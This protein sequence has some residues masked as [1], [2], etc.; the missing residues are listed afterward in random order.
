M[1]SLSVLMTAYNAADFLDESIS[2][3]LNQTFSD[4]EFFIL[5]NGSTDIS[6]EIIRSYAKQDKRIKVLVNK[7]NKG[8]A[9]AR[10][11]LL[12]NCKTE[13]AAIMDADDISLKNRFKIQLHYMKKYPEVDILGAQMQLFGSGITTQ[14]ITTNTPKTDLAIKSMLLF[15]NGLCHPSVI[16][17]MSKIQQAKI[18]Y[19]ETLPTASDY[20]YL[21]DCCPFVHFDNLSQVLVKYRRHPLQASQKHLPI[22]IRTHIK[23]IKK[24]LIK[25]GIKLPTNLENKITFSNYKIKNLSN[26]DLIDLKK[27]FENILEIAPFYQYPKLDLAAALAALQSII[28]NFWFGRK[29]YKFCQETFDNEKKIIKMI[30]SSKLFQSESN[31]KDTNDFFSF[32]FEDFWNDLNKLKSINQLIKQELLFIKELC[33]INKFL[34]SRK[35]KD[36]FCDAFC[37]QILK[38]ERKKELAVIL[39]YLLLNKDNLTISILKIILLKL[40]IKIFKKFF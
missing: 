29:N 35:I 18:F 5:D 1:P 31:K 12:K 36:V 38:F 33:E 25:L 11:I 22:A 34:N 6:L 7:E 32:I 27:F 39:K 10:N 16:F 8:E 4:F 2:S 30:A 21:V 28:F 9:K 37:W 13:F 40:K 17:R 14:R 15:S 3:I 23:I 19:D 24:Q 20:Q 26:T